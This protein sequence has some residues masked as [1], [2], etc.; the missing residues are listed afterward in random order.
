ML[1]WFCLEFTGGGDERNERDVYK[2][3]VV[4]SFFITDL[5]DSFHKRQ[6]LDIAD[7]AADLDEQD[8]RLMHLSDLANRH[9]DLVGYV[10]NDLDRLAKIVSAAFLFNH[11]KINAPTRPVIRLR[12]LGVCKSL[13][14]TK[15]QIGL[16]PVV[17]HENLAVL[18]RRH[19]SRIDVYIR[20]QLH[21]LNRQPPGLQQRPDRT[22]RQP[23]A[24]AR[25]HAACYKY[26]FGH[27]F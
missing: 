22:R 21:H 6:R 5:S 3:R 24:K 8:V 18:K 10:R 15:I 20:V 4:S 13:V 25:N 12:K 9:F 16:G 1:C 17:G 14:M 7:R 19:R 27:I 11:R 23:F 26:V 2:D